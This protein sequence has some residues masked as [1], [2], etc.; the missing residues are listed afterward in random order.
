MLVGYSRVST[1][2]QKL[3]LQLDALKGAGCEKFFSD[4]ISGASKLKPGLDEALAY[5][6]AGDTLV[7]WKLDRLGRTVK[8]LVDLVQTLQE[9]GIQFRSLTDG[10]D[11]STT[12]GRFFFHVMAALAEMERDLITERTNAGLAAARARGR[13][14]G[15]K[16]AMDASKLDAARK[17]LLAGTPASAVA[18]TLGV[19]RATL[20]R[21]LKVSEDFLPTRASQHQPD[22]EPL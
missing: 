13:M 20:Y 16:R 8:G 7:V 5:L 18:K 17:L 2:D 11:T 12:A 21:G 22:R 15:R 6:R 9:K 14:G 1:E 10:I 3:D 4:Q 19:G